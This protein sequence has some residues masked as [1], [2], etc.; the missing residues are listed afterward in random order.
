[1]LVIA[2]WV[3][4]LSGIFSLLLVPFYAAV[5]G[6]AAWRRQWTTLGLVLGLSPFA[7]GFAAGVASWSTAG[8]LRPASHRPAST[9]IDAFTRLPARPLGCL[10]D[11]GEWVGELA[12]DAGLVYA[13]AWWGPSPSTYTGPIP[14]EQEARSHLDF[15][16]PVDLA[17]LAKDEVVFDGFDH[18]IQPHLGAALLGAAYYD[19][20]GASESDG[21]EIRAA[22]FRGRVLLLEIE[23]NWFPDS[24]THVAVIDLGSGR[25]I[26]NH[27]AGWSRSLPDAWTTLD[28]ETMR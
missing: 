25:L 3:L 12:F 6:W 4:A 16:Q 8:R 7:L 14:T 1:V 10:L 28:P 13:T 19:D 2:P 23:L 18:H 17:R 9:S 20:S 27:P 26:G 24:G 5:F 21:G 11:C 15:G 22:V